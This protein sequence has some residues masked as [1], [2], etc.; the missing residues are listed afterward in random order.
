[1]EGVPAMETRIRAIRRNAAKPPVV[2]RLLLAVSAALVCLGGAAID[3]ITI[4]PA[5]RPG[6]HADSASRIGI[7]WRV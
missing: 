7:T 2:S 1:M 5:D 6:V 4:N 3:R